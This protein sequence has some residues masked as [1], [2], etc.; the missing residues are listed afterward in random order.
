[1]SL[2]IYVAVMKPVLG[3]DEF[4]KKGLGSFL[5]GVRRG[6]KLLWDFKQDSC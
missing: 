3:V 2:F 4:R 6:T 1:M 5:R